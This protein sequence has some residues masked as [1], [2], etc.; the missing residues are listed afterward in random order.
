[1]IREDSSAVLTDVGQY[2]LVVEHLIS[3]MPI[4]A[5]GAIE[6]P[7][8]I[9]CKTT[10]AVEQYSGRIPA[11]KVT[12]HDDVFAVGVTAWMVS[13]IYWDQCLTDLFTDQV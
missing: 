10:S 5:R 8:T 7:K 1:M 13:Y 6:L 9:A 11:S 12:Q 4:E 2:S 3:G